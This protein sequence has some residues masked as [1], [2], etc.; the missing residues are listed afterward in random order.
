MSSIATFYSLPEGKRTEFSEAYRNQRRVTYKRTLF[1]RKEVVTG[2]KFLWE[3][4]DATN[5][6]RTDFPFSGFAFI[7]YFFAFVTSR[8]PKHLESA[9]ASAAVDESYYVF[10]AELAARFAE[11][12]QQHPPDPAGLSAFAAEHNPSGGGDYVQT[13][14]ETH[15]FLV[16]WFGGIATGTCGVL[17]ITF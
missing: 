4:L 14:R 12:L 8:L 1:G 10:S 13:L 17:H 9:L 3:Y 2:E 5:S 6:D 11:Y 7:D 15:D 16:R